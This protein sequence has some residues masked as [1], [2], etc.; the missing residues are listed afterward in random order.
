MREIIFKVFLQ[1]FGLSSKK[2]VGKEKGTI[3]ILIDGLSFDAL[4]YAIKKKYCPTLKKL[5]NGKYKL[6]SYYCGLPAST[7]ATEAL[8]FYGNNYNIPGFTWFDRQLQKFVRGNRSLELTEF[9]DAYVKKRNLLENGS[10]VMGVYSGGATELNM[11][12]R[13]L[14]FSRSLYLLKTAHYFLMALLYPVQLMR[15]IY[16][17]LK[18]IILYRRA[19][20]QSAEET[21]A[22]IVLG[23]FSCFLTEIEIMRNTKRIFVDFLLYD[24]YAHEHGPTHPTTLST[25]RLID[26]YV[27]RIV[28]SAKK[29]QRSYDLIFLSDHGQTE[30]IPYDLHNEQSVVDIKKALH[31]ESYSVIKTFGG[32]IPNKESKELYVVPAG[33]TLQLYFSAYLKN[34][35]HEKEIR[36]IFPHFIE[37]LLVSD[38]FGWVLVRTSPSS[39]ILYGKKG[40]VVLKQD[41]SYEVKGTPFPISDHKEIERI[42]H[43]FQYYSTFSNNGDLVVFGNVKDKMVYAF[44]K[45][46]G[47]HGGFYG[48]MTH[49]F[50]MSDNPSIAGD[51]MAALFDTIAIQV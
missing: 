38:A 10:V 36:N 37:G 43:S 20:R 40:A 18:T 9:E 39:Y 2:I 29:A 24:E 21:F 30:C 22:R 33:S 35:I 50:I 49:P 4:N 12:G 5:S 34:G 15:T 19:N 31:D 7:T 3:I 25:L 44:E 28:H 46:K 48:P 1:L 32:F 41:N 16:L 13:N 47:N 11:S 45:N 42:I 51:S 6:S 14:A 8:L 27:K 17:T 26:R 23:Q